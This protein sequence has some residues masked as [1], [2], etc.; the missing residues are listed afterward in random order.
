[1]LVGAIFVLSG[2]YVSV[3]HMVLPGIESLAVD[4][5]QAGRA[6]LESVQFISGSKGS[7]SLRVSYRY[8][9]QG[10]TYT[11]DRHAP[12][13]LP[14][15]QDSEDAGA[16]LQAA[17]SAGRTVTVW[18]DPENPHRAMLDK[19]V[20]WNH[21]LQLL[22]F[23]IAF[24]A[25]GLAFG[26]IGWSQWRPAA[27]PPNEPPADTERRNAVRLLGGFSLVWWSF[28][29]PATVMVVTEPPTR[30]AGWLVLLFPAFGILLLFKL[31]AVLSPA[32]SD[33]SAPGG[34]AVHTSPGAVPSAP[35]WRLP[36][37][38]GLLAAA[39]LLLWQ[40]DATLAWAA[41]QGW[42]PAAFSE[43]VAGPRSVR[44]AP[45]LSPADRDL[46]TAA[47]DGD[48][49][50]VQAALEAGARINA[51]DDSGESALMQAAAAGQTHVVRHLLARGADVHFANAI[52]R[53][54]RGDTALLRAA[55]RGHADIFQ[56]L[57]E[58][59]ART[60]IHNQWDWTA[61]HMA[62]AG[63]CVPCLESLLARGAELDTTA[64]ASRGETPFLL[65][66]GRGGRQAMAWL[67]DHRVDVYRRDREGYDALGWA[68][69]YQQADNERWLLE[70]LPD[71]IGH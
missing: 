29:L 58:A 47:L 30:P 39:C 5:Y 32:R 17:R 60:D 55:F 34:P 36:A 38:L 9:W 15:R 50:G 54:M 4:R 56:M 27:R 6:E 1:M 23:A 62:A 40:R 51:F 7:R 45:P 8:T 63:D 25:V 24:P 20:R 43:H 19:T 67:R 57:L 49:P 66:A 10:R 18:I 16:R 37:L 53:H 71:L 22:P 14:G 33:M 2:L 52:H 70:H 59:G 31:R 3:A 35:T 64:P 68:R 44:P 28:A 69:F 42:L 13:A 26:A 65:A 41:R 61:V 11:G 21:L 46:L 12:L 48:I